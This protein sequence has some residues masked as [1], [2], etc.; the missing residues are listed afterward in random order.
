MWQRL[1]Y[2]R[3]GLRA[4]DTRYDAVGGR[5]AF[6]SRWIFNKSIFNC[7]C[8]SWRRAL[9]TVGRPGR[10]CCSLLWLAI[11]AWWM[12]EAWA[13]AEIANRTSMTVIVLSCASTHSYPWRDYFEAFTRLTTYSS[14]R[15]ALT[16]LIQEPPNVKDGRQ[17]TRL[18]C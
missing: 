16:F 15:K 10:L 5:Q 11:C 3:A 9:E 6:E 12:L 18:T 2:C 4:I 13:A 8:R 1:I 17:Y 7:T 14:I